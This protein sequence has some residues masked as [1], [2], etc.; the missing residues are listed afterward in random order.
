MLAL[1]LMFLSACA[2]EDRMNGTEKEHTVGG[3][4]AGDVFSPDLARLAR[5]ACLGDT[6]DVEAAISA[7][8]DP[9]GKGYEGVTPLL[10]AVNCQNLKGIE[11]LLDAG[12]DPNHKVGGRFSA[13]YA[14]AT[15]PHPEPLK[16]LLRR[17]GDPNTYSGKEGNEVNRSALQAALSLGIRGH[18]DNWYALLDAGADVNRHD[19]LGHSIAT[20]AVSLTAFDK[21]A[22]LLQ[23]GYN[24]NLADLGSRAKTG[25]IA[26]EFSKKIEDRARLIQMIEKRG[27]Q[28]P[29]PPK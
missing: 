28:I 11:A 13:T 23:R 14:A 15:Q 3:K 8:A 5:A 24:Y 16:L 29:A 12:A 1:G 4:A 20:D 10:W 18:W 26:P 9:N 27:V 22:E 19:D 6:A 17:G 2:G 21:V 25:I 7:G